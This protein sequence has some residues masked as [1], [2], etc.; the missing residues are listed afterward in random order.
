MVEVETKKFFRYPAIGQLIHDVF[1][2]EPDV[3]NRVALLQGG[4][5]QTD[6]DANGDG[7]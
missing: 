2:S 3:Q 5:E 1:D 4:S 7:E 6:V